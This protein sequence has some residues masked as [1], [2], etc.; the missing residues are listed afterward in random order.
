MI[1]KDQELEGKRRRGQERKRARERKRVSERGGANFPFYGAA[2]L[3]VGLGYL[4]VEW[5][6]H[7]CGQ[8]TEG[9]V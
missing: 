1:S 9:R 4:S 6:M 8:M 7:G 2:E 5:G 3:S